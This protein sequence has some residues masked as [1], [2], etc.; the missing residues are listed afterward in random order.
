MKKYFFTAS[1]FSLLTL[2]LFL[3]TLIT[4][5][6]ETNRFN[7]I[8]TE[9]INKNNDKISLELETIKFKFDVKEIS[10]FLETNNPKIFYRKTSIPAKNIKVYIDFLSIFKSEAR[11]KKIILALNQIDINKLKKI[12]VSFKP[13]NFT[14]FLNNSV[15]DGKLNTKIEIYLD[16]ENQ[17]DDF[18]ARGSVEGIKA[19]IFKSLD[20]EKTKFSFFADKTD[21]LIKNFS[22]QAQEI[23]IKEGDLKINLSP[24]LYLESNFKTILNLN[25]KILNYATFL[26]NLSNFENLKSLNGEFNNNF[27]IS[28]DKTYKIKT[29]NY[30]SNG[31][32]SDASLSLKKPIKNLFGIEK[33]DNLKLIDT[34]IKSILNQKNKSLSFSGK[35]SLNKGNFQ[36]FEINNNIEKN[37]LNLKLNADFDNPINFEIINYEKEKGDISNISLELKKHKDLLEFKE[38]R[39][40]EDK[41]LFFLEGIILKNNKF[42]KLKKIFVKTFKDGKENNDFSINYGKK[43]VIDGKRF[44]A[45][46]LP[47]ILKQNDDNKFLSSVKKDI[48]INFKSI[49]AP[50]SEKLNNFRL[51]GTINDG[52][53]VKISSKGDFGNN[54]F[55][56]I[57]L[58]NDKKNK[59][60]YLEIYSDIT[61]PLLTEFSFF[62]G[63]TGGKLLFT[64][65]FDDD[66]S[67]SKLKI[68]NFKVINAPGMVKLLSLADLG[69][70]ADL[71]EGEGI[72]FDLLEIKMEK[73]KEMLK[74]REVLALGPSLS[75][76]MEGYQDASVTSIRGT[77][78][79]AKTLNKMISNIPVIGDIVIP[80][81]V[82]EGLFG[83]SFKLKGPPD[84]IKTTIN[85]IRTITPRFIQK[86]IDKKKTN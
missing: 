17:I 34:K 23:K 84:K 67:T 48:E 58:K 50:L 38:I 59:K 47:K 81:E 54:N 1:V 39:I 86:I 42:L 2:I 71:A 26:P 74:L 43:I 52:K 24:E 83:I 10:L 12:S 82:G 85:P 40:K 44:D 77:L 73:S 76:L 55:L 66:I 69:G 53:F 3:T 4:I 31:K 63:L 37:S 9:K 25:N 72:S 16:K 41:N 75:V 22:G 13:S 6:I 27:A 51:I 8:I 64:S 36:K 30:I 32:I 49:N 61:K 7:K 57:S 62:K 79:P 11:I 45:S 80:K 21:I 68:E 19:K 35:Y 70:L 65:V 29:Y 28:F 56:D 46:K 60:K 20:I 78:V 33:I 5:G 15:K 18:I 14:S